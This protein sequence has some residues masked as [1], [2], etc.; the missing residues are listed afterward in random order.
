MIGK[1]ARGGGQTG[2][3]GLPASPP[4]RSMGSGG[5]PETAR[6]RAFT[7]QHASETGP[8]PG[9]RNPPSAPSGDAVRQPAGA[10]HA[11]A[12]AVSHRFDVSGSRSAAVQ[13]LAGPDRQVVRCG[14]RSRTGRRW[15]SVAA[16]AA[17][18]R[19]ARPLG[20]RR[21]GKA[22]CRLESHRAAYPDAGLQKGFDRRGERRKIRPCQ[23]R[24]NSPLAA[25]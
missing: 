2:A 5:R 19:V 20:D 16:I 1:D 15:K 3:R 14:R 24:R 17:K 23:V 25:R 18:P 8:R 7:T 9:H 11:G 4:M 6:T 22:R 12:A 21:G 10:I 13:G